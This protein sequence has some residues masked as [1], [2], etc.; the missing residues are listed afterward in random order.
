MPSVVEQ[1]NSSAPLVP[2]VNIATFLADLDSP[3]AELVIHSVHQ[4]CTTSGFFQITGHG[5][6]EELQRDLSQASR[7]FFAL[8]F[9]EKTKLDAKT[10]IGHRGY[11]ILASQSYHED[12]LLDL[13][14]GFCV[15]YDMLLN[16]P[17]VQARRFFVGPNREFRLPVEAY[18]QA[19]HSLALKV[20]DLVAR[21]LPYGPHIF[22]EFTAGHTVAL[23]VGAHTDFGA[24]TLLLQDGQPGFEAL[25]PKTN[26]F[27][28]VHPTPNAFV[29]NVGDMPSVWAGDEY[30]S[31]VHRVINKAPADRYSAAFFY[32]GAL[33]CPLTPLHHKGAPDGVKEALTVEK[34]MIRHIMESC[35]LPEKS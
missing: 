33:D 24:I 31:S 2:T 1:E 34:H 30:K 3:A 6:P 5:L 28:P 25:D 10:M 14:E 17:E 21:T 13:E 8:G 35:T 7:K 20:L 26:Y 19:I 27:V 11:D 4:A 15:G 18:F 22:D 9:Q 12:V 16:D 23:G 32:D 29:F